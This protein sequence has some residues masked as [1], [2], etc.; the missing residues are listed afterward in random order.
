MLIILTEYIAASPFGAYYIGMT[1]LR[2]VMAVD[3][4]LTSSGWALLSIQ[5][6]EVVAVGKIKAAPPSVPMA[7]RLGRLQDT[8]SAL[9]ERL[10]LGCS[11][12]LVCEA[13]TTMK[14][15]HNAIK[16]E[17]VRGLFESNARRCGVV[18]PGRVNPRSVQFEVMGLKGKQVA[19]A[20]VKAAAV[21]TS[22]YLFASALTR[23]GIEPS[24]SNLAKHQDIVDAILIGRFAVL[25]IQGA[26][27]AQ[28]ALEAVF[29]TQTKQHR[30]SWRARACSI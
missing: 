21:R 11:D 9:L 20:E 18:V 27:G 26:L 17:Q 13:P 7:T 19:R 2:Y 10:S 6:G 15:P 3:P 28:H 29:E 8:I 24:D 14:D 12:V 5:G 23:L 25:R 30:S 1:T 4:S 22:Q 16:V